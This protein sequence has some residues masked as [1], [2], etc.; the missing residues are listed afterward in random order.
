MGATPEDS[1]ESEVYVEN[2]LGTIRALRVWTWPEGTLR[3][4]VLTSRPDGWD[5]PPSPVSL[6]L[7]TVLCSR[8]AFFS[9]A[10]TPTL[11]PDPQAKVT[12]CWS[13]G[14]LESAYSMLHLQ[15]TRNRVS[16]TAGLPGRP[17]PPVLVPAGW[18]GQPRLRPP[19]AGSVQAPPLVAVRA[20][21]PPPRWRVPL[22]SSPVL[23]PL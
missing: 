5:R 9:P 23:L 3:P 13:Q 2:S 18:A 20:L 17:S 7:L 22:R 15:S 1:G 8:V 21:A 14:I 12:E 10:S 11:T 19:L 16:L 4:L 6:T